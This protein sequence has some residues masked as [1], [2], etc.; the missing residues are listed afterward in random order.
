VEIMSK[1][2]HPPPK[3][4]KEDRRFRALLKKLVAVPVSEIHEKR[5]EYQKKRRRK[6]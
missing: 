4:S 2:P 3:G 1:A 6:P 5:K